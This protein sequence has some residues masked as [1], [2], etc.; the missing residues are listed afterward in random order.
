MALAVGWF[1]SRVALMV[2]ST[3]H[4]AAWVDRAAGE[5]DTR[6][7]MLGWGQVALG[8]AVGS[9]PVWRGPPEFEVAF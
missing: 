6:P 8:S 2:Q 4:L 1:V 7:G 3:K 9:S 5:V